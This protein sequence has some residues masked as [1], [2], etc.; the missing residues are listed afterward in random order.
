MEKIFKELLVTYKAEQVRNVLMKIGGSNYRF[1]AV[2]GRKNNLAT[3]NI[4]T[5]PASG[6]TE[7]ITNAIDAVLEKE[8]KQKEKPSDIKSPRRASELWYGIESGKISKIANPHDKRLK[9]LSELVN[10]TL[11]DSGQTTKPTV[12]IRDKGI[13]L[14][15][16]QFSKTILD[17]NGNNKI[18][19][20]I[21]YLD[22]LSFEYLPILP[23]GTCILAG[24]SAQVPVV[25]DIG[26]IEKDFEPNNKTRSLI[27][28]W[29]ELN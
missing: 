23:T 24:L 7:R 1:E 8:W 18:G 22:K 5:D 13:G 12:E 9:E 15:P 10:V 27:D 26:A 19:K 17:L 3:I 2:G 29:E 11:Y 14:E 28:N 25:V 4:G 6:V 16:E 20:T 21:S